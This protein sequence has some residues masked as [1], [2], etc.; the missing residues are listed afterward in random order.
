MESTVLMTTFNPAQPL[1]DDVQV[2]CLPVYQADKP[3]WTYRKVPKVS[4]FR[5][6]DRIPSW[7][8]MPLPFTYHI[9]A[10]D[11]VPN[12]PEGD[13]Q[14]LNEEGT[15]PPDSSAQ[16]RYCVMCPV[17]RGSP[18]LLP[19]CLCENWCRIA[20][21]YQTHLGRICPCH[22]RILE[23][24]R[25]IIVMSHPYLE[26][27]EGYV[28]LPTR[29]TIRT[30]SISNVLFGCLVHRTQVPR[31][32]MRT[33]DLMRLSLDQQSTSFSYGRLARMC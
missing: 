23:P 30:D 19:C 7:S 29:S 6:F 14:V 9:C 16:N 20:C 13:L 21:R 18:K 15:V 5:S 22:V 1:E 28:V 10:E 31:E 26:D 17:R 2:Q 8:R 3:Q 4:S 33:L 27:F 11:L 25:K 32:H 24:R 12:L